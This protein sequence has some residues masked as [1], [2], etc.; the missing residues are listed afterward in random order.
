MGKPFD[1]LPT[2]NDDPRLD[3]W[4]QT[5]DLGNGMQSRG[6]FIHTPELADSFGFPK[7]LAGKTCLDVATA[8]G[9]WGFEMERRGAASVTAI[10]VRNFGEIDILPAYRATL[11]PEQ[12][13]N[14]DFQCQYLTA[15]TLRKS[16][17]NY[18]HANVYTMTPENLGTFDVAYCGSL[19]LHLINPLQCLINI[20]AVTRE[21]AIVE[22][23]ANPHLGNVL[24]GQPAALFGAP[25]DEPFPGRDV[26]YWMIGM[27]ALCKMLRYAGFS[28][29]EP[30]GYLPMAC[31]RPAPHDVHWVCA[32][33]AYV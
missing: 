4:Y 22:T 3:N 11:T 13:G 6:Y 8:S 12:L 20:R 28:R 9:F 23:A 10:D 27:E 21:M 16:K 18:R 15:H 7:S 5:V 1:P 14:N 25:G 33:V 24:P 31:R 29:V 19:L 2:R 30:K 32:A 17:V 26:T